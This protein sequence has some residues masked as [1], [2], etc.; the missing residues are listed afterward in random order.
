LRKD[1]WETNVGTDGLRDEQRRVVRL[2]C[3]IETHAQVTQELVKKRR[4]GDYRRSHASRR[5]S[6]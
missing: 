3:L 1:E 5:C 6:F 2:D 4:S